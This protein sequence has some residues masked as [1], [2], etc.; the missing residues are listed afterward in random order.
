VDYVSKIIKRV[1][2]A[3]SENAVKL[4]NY[5]GLHTEDRRPNAFICIALQKKI[6]RFSR[7]K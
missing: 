6:R 5:C 3:R 7:K 1:R 4:K 2:L